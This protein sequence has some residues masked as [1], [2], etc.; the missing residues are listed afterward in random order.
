[1][2]D[3]LPRF[4]PWLELGLAIALGLV[5]YL[6]LHRKDL[7]EIAWIVAAIVGVARIGYTVEMRNELQ[8]MHRLVE[9]LGIRKGSDA[10]LHELVTLH[11]QIASPDLQLLRDDV[12]RRAITSLQP[13]AH[14]LTS[15][16]LP[17]SHYYEWLVHM[18]DGVSKGTRVRAVTTMLE[19]EWDDSAPERKFLDANVR[20]AKRGATVQRLFIIPADRVDEFQQREVARI[21]SQRKLPKLTGLVLTRE[22][23]IALDDDLVNR[24][25]EGFIVFGERAALIDVTVPPNQARGQITVSQPRIGALVRAFEQATLH[26]EPIPRH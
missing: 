3:R 8:P 4:L 10:Q 12:M 1:V 5:L 20:A 19:S 2:R 7:A 9:A 22:A 11:D 16:L 18:L 24:L 21:H 6:P 15:E 14:E 13:L 23:L 26:S 17:P 25:G